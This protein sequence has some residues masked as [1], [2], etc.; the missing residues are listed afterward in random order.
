MKLEIKTPQLPESVSDATVATWHKKPGDAI[1]RGE[2]IGD[3]ETDKV[4]LELPS[5]EAGVLKSIEQQPGAVVVSGQLLAVIDVSAVASASAD[6]DANSASTVALA[7]GSAGAGANGSVGAGAV[8]GSGASSAGSLRVAPA[9]R[10]LIAEHGLNATAI[11]GSGKHGTI[12]KE[13][14]LRHVREATAEGAAANAGAANTNAAGATNATNANAARAAGTPSLAARSTH[15]GSA[16]ASEPLMAAA[17]PAPAH[18]SHPMAS[19]TRGDKRVPMTRLRARTAERLVLSRNETAALTTFNEVNMAP[20]MAL[21]KKFGE[22]FLKH[23]GVKLGFMSIFT[24]ACIEALRVFPVVN[25]SIDAGDVIYH[26]YFDIGIAISSPKG[27]V[28][29]VIRNADQL[30]L[31]QVEKQILDYGEK[32]KGGKMTLEDLTGGTFSI[33]NGGIFGSMLSTPII[34]PPQTAILGM[35]SIRQRPMAENGEVVIQPVMYLALTYDHR[36][37]DGREAVQFLVRIKDSIEEPSRLLL[38]L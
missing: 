16:S 10:R 2:I 15:T 21:R 1:E 4:T 22:E 35:H 26:N 14:V 20:V 38:N 27:L 32:A 8:V 24:H 29:P 18:T 3:L 19:D 36:L 23:H 7:A 25:A 30:T 5:P 17:T 37:I 31:A 34:N 9:A 33:T 28:V 11:A 6:L 13:D 12:L